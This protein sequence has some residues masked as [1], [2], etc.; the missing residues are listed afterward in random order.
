MIRS[1]GRVFK[2]VGESHTYIKLLILRCPF[3][4]T[5]TIINVCF[6]HYSFESISQGSE[7]KLRNTVCILQLQAHYYFYI[8]EVYG[9][10]MRGL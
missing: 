2:K 9:A 10:C 4:A 3:D 7:N 6:L 8:M 5:S 1:L